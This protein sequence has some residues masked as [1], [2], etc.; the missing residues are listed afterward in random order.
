MVTLRWQ[1]FKM[2]TH[3]FFLVIKL[4]ITLISNHFVFILG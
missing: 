3:S 4:D 1:H 2:V